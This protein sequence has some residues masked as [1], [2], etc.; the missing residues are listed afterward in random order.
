MAKPAAHCPE[1]GPEE[2]SATEFGSLGDNY[3][4]VVKDKTIASPKKCSPNNLVL[5]NV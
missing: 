2:L 4:K 5:S 1:K 3:V